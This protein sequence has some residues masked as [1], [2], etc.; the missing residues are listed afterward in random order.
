MKLLPLLGAGDGNKAPAFHIVAP[1]LP[2]YAFSDGVTKRGFGLAQYSE[3]LHKLMLKL[4]Y[5][6]YITQGG[7]WGAI[8]TRVMARLYPQ[9]LKA[10]H[11]NMIMPTEP[12]SFFQAPVASVAHKVT[13]YT[14]NEIA[15]IERSTW[16]RKEGFGYNLEQST[17]PQTL[18]YGLADSPVALLG[19]IYEKLHD[20]TDDF[21]WSDDEILTWVSLYWFSVAGPAANVRIY[22]E[23]C[24][25][26]P[27]G[28]GSSIVIQWARSTSLVCRTVGADFP[29]NSGFRQKVGAIA[30]VRWFTSATTIVEGTLPLPSSLR[31]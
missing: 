24:H 30:S 9:S 17:K 25:P 11:L 28:P 22:Y 2:N 6:E 3:C 31:L 5:N 14:A 13:P 19:W 15:G 18:G 29:K 23:A 12:P 21:A 7:D 16:F 8:I 26:G 10:Q 20:W 1:S 4:G 27:S